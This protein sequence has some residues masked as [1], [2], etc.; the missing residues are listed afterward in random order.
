MEKYF[1]KI[2][3]DR[4]EHILAMVWN[5][6][7]AS[8]AQHVLDLLSH[9][10]VYRWSSI[11]IVVMESMQLRIDISPMSLDVGIPRGRLIANLGSCILELLDG[12]NG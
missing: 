1:S 7:M 9:E 3:L 11:G 8:I 10:S 2:D 6:G 5:W 4:V 12:L